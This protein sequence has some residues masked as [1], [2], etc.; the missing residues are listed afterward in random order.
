MLCRFCFIPGRI[1][2]RVVNIYLCLLA[3][4]AGTTDGELR[5]SRGRLLSFYFCI[6]SL[7]DRSIMFIMIRASLHASRLYVV[8]VVVFSH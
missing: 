8:V 7:V 6:P 2:V 1:S 5:T 4:F 3:S